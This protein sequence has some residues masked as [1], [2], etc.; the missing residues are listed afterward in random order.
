MEVFL[1]AVRIVFLYII[2]IFFSWYAYGSTYRNLIIGTWEQE[3]VSSTGKIRKQIYTFS[4]AGDFSIFVTEIDASTSK[5]FLIGG[6]WILKD[7]EVHYKITFSNDPR[8]PIGKEVVNIILHITDEKVIIKGSS[9]RISTAYKV[10][11]I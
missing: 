5:E 6:T 11:G 9:G 4:D 7:K 1:P 10:K 8:M 3:K 2:A